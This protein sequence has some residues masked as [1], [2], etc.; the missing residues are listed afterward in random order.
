MV[1]APVAGVMRRLAAGAYDALLLG[2]LWMVATFAIVMFR[3]GEPVP[4]G[5]PAYRLLLLT[6][7]ALYFGVSWV[8]GGQTLGMRAWRLRVE[9]AS[10]EPVDPRTGAVRLFAGA[11]TLA[12]CGLGLAWLWIDRDELTWHDRLAGTRVLLLPKDPG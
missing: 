1:Q 2:A 5:D 3:G 8:R 7:A 11:L 4:A 6:L 9:R 12:T 10:G